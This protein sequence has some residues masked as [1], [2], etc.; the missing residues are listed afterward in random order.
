MVVNSATSVDAGQ[1]VSTSLAGESVY[2][3]A[4]ITI[5]S[6]ALAL[7]DETIDTYGRLDY[8]INNAG[9]T[10]TV[11]HEDIDALHGDL[12]KTFEV[13]VFG[14]W[15]VINSPSLTFADPMIRALSTSRRSQAF[16]PSVRRLRTR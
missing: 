15:T 12:R 4:D 5:R 16:V 3:K 13:N 9:W 10:T 8:L 7:I 11:Q 1:A 6:E 14:T 2:V